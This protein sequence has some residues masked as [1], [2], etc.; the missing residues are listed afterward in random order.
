MAPMQ[1]IRAM[2]KMP[3]HRMDMDME[4]SRDM[5]MGMASTVW[6]R[7]AKRARARAVRV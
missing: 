6:N 1:A 7:T 2:V 5:N 3:E 4:M